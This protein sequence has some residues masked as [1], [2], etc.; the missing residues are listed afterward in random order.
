MS[1]AYY[2]TGFFR[3]SLALYMGCVLV[4]FLLW[5]N[6]AALTEPYA[7]V[8]LLA[9]IGWGFL[10]VFFPSRDLQLPPFMI[11]LILLVSMGTVQMMLAAL[12]HNINPKN[13]TLPL[14]V[15]V[16]VSS[17]LVVR[18]H[19]TAGWAVLFFSSLLVLKWHL[20]LFVPTIHIAA[21]FLVPCMIVFAAHLFKYQIEQANHRAR[22]ARI[23]LQNAELRQAAEVGARDVAAQRVY[24]VRTLTEDMLYRIAYNPEPV[25][26]EEIKQFRFTEAQLRDTIRGRYVVNQKILDAA[27]EARRRGAKVDILDER[28]EDLPVSVMRAVTTAAVDMLED[29]SGG[30]ITIRAFPVGDPIA[31]MLVHDGNSEDDEPSAVEISA[32]GEIDRF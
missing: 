12:P 1:S 31:V 29:A 22:Q 16:L 14:M 19:I 3:V 8:P 13:I 2:S 6:S 25:T 9:S 15:I 26:A 7:W 32:T 21:L 20:V 28:G 23:L 5:Y 24:E 10:L 11:P 17:V 27:L 4:E 30:T 18:N